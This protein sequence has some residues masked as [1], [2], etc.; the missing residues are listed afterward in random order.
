MLRAYETR[1]C[2]CLLQE[3]PLFDTRPSS[4]CQ[5][6]SWPGV[7]VLVPVKVKGTVLNQ[8]NSSVVKICLWGKSNSGLHVSSSRKKTPL[9]I[10][11]TKEDP[12]TSILYF[13]RTSRTVPPIIFIQ[14]TYHPNYTFLR[15]ILQFLSSPAIHKQTAA[16]RT[17]ET[18][19]VAREE[20]SLLYS[21]R[22]LKLVSPNANILHNMLH[23]LNI[24]NEYRYN[25]VNSRCHLDFSN[26]CPFLFQDPAYDS[27]TGNCDTAWK[28]TSTDKRPSFWSWVCT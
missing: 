6:S 5:S 9:K 7:L 12:T 27:T 23:L 1:D 20:F 3:D 10:P 16:G 13:Q 21:C 15:R 8:S 18:H 24:R 25:P 4:I 17:L 2:I 19:R 22:S 28:M 11:G 14:R 26:F